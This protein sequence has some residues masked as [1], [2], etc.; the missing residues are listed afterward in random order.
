MKKALASLL[1]IAA[2]VSIVWY[3][4]KSDTTEAPSNTNNPPATPPPVIAPNSPRPGPTPLPGVA[5]DILTG[6]LQAS[7]NKAKGNLML[8]TKLSSD[9]TKETNIYITTSRD[10]GAL[11]GK[12]V[13]AKIQGTLNDFVLDDITAKE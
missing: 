9:S 5:Q 6:T 11:I 8:V 10:Y 4:N 13:V 1:L 12:E 7:D 2:I 3:L